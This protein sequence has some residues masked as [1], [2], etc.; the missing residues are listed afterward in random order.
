MR[1]RRGP[2]KVPRANHDHI[3]RFILD[4]DGIIHEVITLTNWPEFSFALR[5][6]LMQKR[7]SKPWVLWR[8]DSVEGG[9]YLLYVQ[10]QNP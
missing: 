8:A 4:N 5:A 6:L 9:I 1:G 3:A 7:A 10:L 2:Q